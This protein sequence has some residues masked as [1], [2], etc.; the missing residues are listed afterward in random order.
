MWVKV[1]T[2][3]AL[4]WKYIVSIMKVNVTCKYILISSLTYTRAKFKFQTLEINK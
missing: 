2:L 4:E 3:G 1:H